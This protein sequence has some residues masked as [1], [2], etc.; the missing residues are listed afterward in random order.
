MELSSYLLIIVD[1]AVCVV[2]NVR[3]V[4]NK[5]SGLFLSRCQIKNVIQEFSWQHYDHLK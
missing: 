3:R 5:R 4:D 2:E 1:V